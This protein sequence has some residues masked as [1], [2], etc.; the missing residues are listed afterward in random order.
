MPHKVK[1]EGS[2]SEGG[3]GTSTK[4][5]QIL[6]PHPVVDNGGDSDYTPHRSATLDIQTK[7]DHRE[8]HVH[9]PPPSP[10]YLTV[11]YFEMPMQLRLITKQSD[12]SL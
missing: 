1:N 7:V 9:L 6:S 5:C 4:T 2:A 8:K 10:R 3:A 12:S 11:L